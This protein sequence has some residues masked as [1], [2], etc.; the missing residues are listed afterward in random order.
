MLVVE[1]D[2]DVE[3]HHVENDGVSLLLLV[4]A[5]IIE[6][7]ARSDTPVLGDGEVVAD[8]SIQADAGI[9]CGVFLHLFTV[10][11]G[12]LVANAVDVAQKTAVDA[13]LSGGFAGN[14]HGCDKSHN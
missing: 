9:L 4:L 7:D 10:D 13:E 8:T 2:G 5:N 3:V 1:Q 14:Q 12:V 6:V 11:V